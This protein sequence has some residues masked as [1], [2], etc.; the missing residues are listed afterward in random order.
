MSKY[1]ALTQR[2]AEHDGPEWRASFAEIEKLLGFPLPKAA[3]GRGGW[4]DNAGQRAPARAWLD[5]GWSA[6]PDAAARAVTFSRN[7]AQPS[8]LD[9]AL[10]APVAQAVE[11]SAPSAPAPAEV[12]PEA[13]K[14]ASRSAS[15]QMHVKSWGATA[16]IAAGAAVLAGVGTLIVRGLMK[17]AKSD[18]PPPN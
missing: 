3:L 4:W 5:Q 17:R 6:R 15:R 12:Q 10:E 11:P 2:L 13:M 9:A 7:D 18:L 14:D 8:A 16:A 1:D